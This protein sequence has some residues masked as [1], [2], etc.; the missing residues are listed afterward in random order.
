[1][2]SV[3]PRKNIKRLLEAFDLFKSQSTS[4]HQ[5][6]LYGRI[7]WKTSEIFK[8]YEQLQYKDAVHFIESEAISVQEILGAAFGLSYVSLFEGF[9]IPILEAFE[10]GIPVITSNS[11]SMPEVAGDAALLVDPL[12][13]KSIAGAMHQLVDDEK[14]CQDLVVRSR[15]QKEKFSW[16]T[17]AEIVW[18][19]LIE[20]ARRSV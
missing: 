16:D 5:L 11:S 14:L 9:G 17:S 15:F 19:K 18:Q 4:P 20:T 3:H 7:A 2:G 10:C 8:T 13:I 12:D 6:V 1:V